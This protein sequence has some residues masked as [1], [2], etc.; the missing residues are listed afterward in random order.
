MTDSDLRARAHD[1]DAT[2]RVGKRGIQGVED[3]LDRQL[4]D[5]D[6]VKVRFLRSARGGTT[7]DELAAE[8]A[9]SVNATLVETRGNT[10]V[11][12]R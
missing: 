8:L 6:L 2:I 12:H 5:T 10:A 1:L 3:E 11:Y 9:T 4:S 7:T